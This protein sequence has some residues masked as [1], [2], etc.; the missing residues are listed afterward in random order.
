[1]LVRMIGLTILI[2]MVFAVAGKRA[3]SDQMALMLGSGIGAALIV[4]I[5]IARDKMEGTLELLC[6]LPIA[7]RALAASRVAAGA[8]L[9]LPWAAGAGVL[10]PGLPRGLGLDPFGVGVLAWL[11]LLLLSACG[12]ALLARFELESV[13]GAPFVAMLLLLVLLPRV[14]RALSPA[15][16]F[17]L[18]LDFLRQP[19]APALLAFAMLSTVV[20]CTAIALEITSRAFAAYDRDTTRR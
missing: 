17:D 14:L 6:G 3:S 8:L 18:V 19:F 15:L 16:S 4:P 1:M 2:G 9:S 20:A 10:A 13:L 12:T 11:A 7:P 5:G